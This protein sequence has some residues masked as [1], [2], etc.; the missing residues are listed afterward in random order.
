MLQDSVCMCRVFNYKVKGEG[1][2]MKF[3]NS[4]CILNLT[5]EYYSSLFFTEERKNPSEPTV[6]LSHPVPERLNF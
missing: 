2:T 1:E 4:V 5:S 6:H 3:G